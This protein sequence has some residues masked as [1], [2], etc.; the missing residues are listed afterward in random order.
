MLKSGIILP[1]KSNWS[2][3]LHIGPKKGDQWR[4]CGDYRALNARTI[5]DRYPVRHIEDFSQCLQGK[6]IFSTLDLIKAYHQIHVAEEDIPKITITT[7]FGIYEF[8][9]IFF[10]LK[11]AAQTFQ[12]FIDGILERLEFYYV[13]IDYIL[14]A[15]SSLE[16]H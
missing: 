11:N 9:K 7:L 13:Y 15:S 2:S 1:S 8:I 3:A 10:D 4:P 6:T 12:C 16:G 5:P 14:I